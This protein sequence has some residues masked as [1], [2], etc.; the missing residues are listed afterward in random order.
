MIRGRFFGPDRALLKQ[1]FL[2]R[3]DAAQ[4]LA[5]ALKHLRGRRPLV[6]AIPRGGVP[7]GAAIARAL[8]GSLDV[9]LV[10]K[11]G[12]P[13]DPELAVGAVDEAGTV[14]LC[15]HAERLGADADYLAVEARRQLALIRERRLRYTPG[16]EPADPAGRVVIVVDDGLATGATMHTALAAVRAG[17]PARLICAVPVAAPDRLAR[18]TTAADDT[19]CLERPEDFYAVGQFYRHFPPVTDQEVVALLERAP[20][21]T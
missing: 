5:N 17:H 18:M 6:L 3:E 14:N 8:E 21:A 4:R 16:R 12:A 13:G 9:V 19:V 11:L 10:R 20:P 1:M 2:D 15:R 7:I